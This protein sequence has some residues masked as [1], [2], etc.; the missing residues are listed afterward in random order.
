MTTE[1]KTHLYAEVAGS[2]TGLIGEE[3]IPCCALCESHIDG[4]DISDLK[5]HLNDCEQK[6]KLRKLIKLYEKEEAQAKAIKVV[7]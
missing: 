4:F 5:E 2:G 7:A 1:R 3:I 6:D